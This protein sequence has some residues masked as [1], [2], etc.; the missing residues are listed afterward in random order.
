MSED[1]GKQNPG[2]SLTSKFQKHFACSYKSYLG[3]DAAYNFINITIE[4]SNYFTDFMKKQFNKDI[5]MTKVDDE[6]FEKSAKSSVYCNVWADDDVKL[7]DHCHITW[8]FRCS[9]R[10]HCNI[11]IELN[12]KIRIVF[13]K[14]KN[15]DSH[16]I[17]QEPGKFDFKINVIPVGLEEYMGFNI[18]NKLIFINSFQCLSC[19]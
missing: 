7:R 17:I 10:R 15:Y 8:K 4:E 9:A 3:E 13:Q 16:L 19:I 18:F 6:D 5:V 1:N 12:H 11:K 14:L 2:E